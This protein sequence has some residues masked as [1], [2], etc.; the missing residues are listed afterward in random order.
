MSKILTDVAGEIVAETDKAI[1]L[2]DG[3]AKAWLPKSMIEITRKS[4]RSVVV[5]LP[6]SLAISKDLA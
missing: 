2:D 5:T 3:R 1:L 6:E 4:G